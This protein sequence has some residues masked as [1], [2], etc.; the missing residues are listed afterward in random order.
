MSDKFKGIISVVVLMAILWIVYYPYHYIEDY[1]FLDD[2]EQLLLPFY[3]II[4]LVS[5]L[6]HYICGKKLWFSDERILNYV[7][8]FGI[9]L[10]IDAIMFILFL[11]AGPSNED[12]Y[13]PFSF[14]RY[15]FQI[16][17]CIIIGVHYLWSTLVMLIGTLVIEKIKK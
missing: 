16:L 14:P 2:E 5:C 11:S 15:T 10:G 12:P 9:F 8:S 7:V 13:E 3:A 6:Q 1:Y 17:Y 4:F